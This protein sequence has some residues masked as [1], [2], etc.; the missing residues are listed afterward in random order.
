MLNPSVMFSFRSSFHLK[1]FLAGKTLLC[2]MKNRCG[3]EDKRYPY[4][5][6]CCQLT[7]E[8]TAVIYSF[9]ETSVGSWRTVRQTGKTTCLLASHTPMLTRP[10]NHM[11]QASGCE[12][13][14]D[15]GRLL[16]QQQAAA[17]HETKFK[18]KEKGKRKRQLIA[19]EKVENLG[20]KETNKKHNKC[21]A[22]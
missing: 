20:L 2:R 15:D 22:N 8:H 14:V 12:S 21:S 18:K 19:K 17:P 11:N 13:D 7:L 5:R 1:G 6:I 9:L 16:V 4:D 10:V 3:Q